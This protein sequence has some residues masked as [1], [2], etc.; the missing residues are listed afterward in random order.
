MLAP[1]SPLWMLL[2][3]MVVC[4]TLVVCLGLLLAFN[5][6]NGFVAKDIVTIFGAVIPVLSALGAFD[7]VK[8]K[9]VKK[10]ELQEE[11]ELD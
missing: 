1:N 3:Q 8:S 2:R 11:S 10:Q 4:L 5:Y 7:A 9:M 6:K